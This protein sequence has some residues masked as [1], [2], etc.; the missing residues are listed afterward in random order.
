[1]SIRLFVILTIALIALMQWP[2]IASAL[3]W[4]RDAIVHGEIWRLITGNLTHTNWPHMIMNTLAL[5][6][7]TF[8]FRAHLTAAR[9]AGLIVSLSLF[10]GL[11]LFGSSMHNYVG[12]SG[13]LHGIFAWG[14]CRDILAKD[15]LGIVML[16]GIILKVAY[17]Q[18]YGA[19]ALSASLIQ[20]R[21]A[22]EAHLA[23]LV[24]GI[25]IALT[26]VVW[27]TLRTRY[28]S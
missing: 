9:L 4:Q 18:V 2:A 20:A 25:V 13:V 17:E 19:S 5:A 12:L 11:C 1:M 10:I 3:F 27:R 24:G 22:T 28:A 26:P 6:I 16:V 14:A 15:K 21:V 23:G 8:I 7:I